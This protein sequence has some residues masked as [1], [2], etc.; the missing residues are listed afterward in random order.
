VWP[1]QFSSQDNYDLVKHLEAEPPHSIIR[2]LARD[3]PVEEQ[4]RV[5]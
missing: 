2:A 5:L 4:P 3:L 1:W